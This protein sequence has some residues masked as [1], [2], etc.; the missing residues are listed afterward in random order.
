MQDTSPV[1]DLNVDRLPGYSFS[2]SLPGTTKSQLKKIML[3]YEDRDH[4]ISQAIREGF[5][6]QSADSVS[7]WLL[8]EKEIIETYKGLAECAEKSGAQAELMTINA[9][10]EN[11]HDYLGEPQR[12]GLLLW[13]VTDGVVSFRGSHIISLATLVGVPY[14]GCPSFAQTMAQDKFT[15]FLLCRDIGIPVPQSALVEDGKVLRSFIKKGDTGP[16]FVKPNG[17]GNKIGINERSLC[18]T[19]GDALNQ[20]TSIGRRL[21]DRM[22]VQRFVDGPEIRMTFINADPEHPKY[23]YDLIDCN[24]RGASYIL[25]EKREEKYSEDFCDFEEWPG[26][27]DKERTAITKKMQQSVERLARYVRIKDYFAFDFRLD[28]SGIP[29]MIDFNPGAFL[30]GKDL[31]AYAQKGFGHPLS[32]VLYTAMK[33][34]HDGRQPLISKHDGLSFR[35]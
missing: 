13:N 32:E 22:I 34:S 21:R 33:N 16:F 26:M 29:Q 28:Q 1:L 25:S 11:N 20:A 23:G 2:H 19:I 12:R 8:G 17:L 18:S 31:D 3:L 7:Y 24:S 10:I 9:F 6:P 14:F 30:Y 4:W 35:L 5:S 27:S 15:L